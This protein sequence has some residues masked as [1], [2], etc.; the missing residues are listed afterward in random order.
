LYLVLKEEV[1]EFGMKES[2]P[3]LDHGMKNLKVSGKC[4]DIISIPEEVQG[5]ELHVNEFARFY[6]LK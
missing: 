4:N 1:L 6:R 5:K 2:V 3:L